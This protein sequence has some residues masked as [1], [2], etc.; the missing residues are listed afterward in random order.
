M[1]IEI[2]ASVDQTPALDQLF[3]GLMPGIDINRQAIMVSPREQAIIGGM[4]ESLKK[5]E[6]VLENGKFL[7]LA[8]GWSFEGKE[9]GFFIVH[10]PDGGTWYPNVDEQGR[11]ISGG[12][13]HGAH[14]M[15]GIL[16]PGQSLRVRRGGGPP[17]PQVEATLGLSPEEFPLI[18]ESDDGSTP[19]ANPDWKETVDTTSPGN[20]PFYPGLDKA[21]FQ[22][23]EPNKPATKKDSK[24]RLD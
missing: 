18:K 9:K 11:M 24:L 21:M 17:E 6:I 22:T 10:R 23:V 4:V 8:A 1:T 16:S 19:G 20:A 13:V 3:T 15:T 14:K 2:K 7:K 5:G 12:F